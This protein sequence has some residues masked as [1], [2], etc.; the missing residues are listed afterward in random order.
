MSDPE[1]SR[2]PSHSSSSSSRKKQSQSPAGHAQERHDHSSPLA[3]N[4]RSSSSST[5]STAGR[6]LFDD[7]V[8]PP[9]TR[10][11]SPGGNANHRHNVFYS[12]AAMQSQELYSSQNPPLLPLLP[13][14]Q[15][16]QHQS[17]STE[18]FFEGVVGFEA[19]LQ[20]LKQRAEKESQRHVPQ[21]KKN[22]K[23]VTS[24]KHNTGASKKEK[25]LHEK[26]D[27]V[28]LHKRD[29]PS[30]PRKRSPS[31]CS[32]ASDR[33]LAAEPPHSPSSSW[34]WDFFA[35]P[36]TNDGEENVAEAAAQQHD[37]L[38]DKVAELDDMFERI[39][40]AVSWYRHEWARKHHHAQQLR[41]IGA[42]GTTALADDATVL[43][44]ALIAELNASSSP[45]VAPSPVS[46]LREECSMRTDGGASVLSVSTSSKRL[47]GGPLSPSM[48][49][50]ARRGL[51][52]ATDEALA[53]LH[54]RT[55]P[56]VPGCGDGGA[57]GGPSAPSAYFS[58]EL[59]HELD[60]HH[61]HHRPS[62]VQGR[63]GTDGVAQLTTLEERKAF[64]AHRR[65]R[66]AQQ[67]Q[68]GTAA[69][70]SGEGH[71][72]TTHHQLTKDR[73]LHQVERKH[74]DEAMSPSPHRAAAD[75]SVSPLSVASE[76]AV[77]SSA[78]P[79]LMMILG[80]GGGGGGASTSGAAA[81]THSVLSSFEASPL[82]PRGP[83][84]S[85]CVLPPH[86]AEATLVEL[87]RRATRAA[88]QLR[89]LSHR[90]GLLDRICMQEVHLKNLREE[91]AGL[92]AAVKEFQQQTAQSQ[93]KQGYA[94]EAELDA[95]LMAERLKHQAMIRSLQA[96]AKTWRTV[97][98]QAALLGDVD[99]K[100]VTYLQEKIKFQ[101]DHQLRGGDTVNRLTKYLNLQNRLADALQLACEQELVTARRGAKLVESRAI[102]K[103]LTHSTSP[104]P[105][106]K[107]PSRLRTSLYASVPSAGRGDDGD[108]D[109]LRQ[110]TK[111]VPLLMSAP[112]VPTT[113]TAL[114]P[115]KHHHRGKEG[116]PSSVVVGNVWG[117]MNAKMI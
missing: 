17:S 116:S 62:V 11:N 53:M 70:R 97:Q 29:H 65:Q 2:S 49:P 77:S 8:P 42:S 19:E 9:S 71:P 5:A 55:I 74:N 112:P 14:Q 13:P 102:L 90:N 87:T 94:N 21:R 117:R 85:S 4:S 43:S 40:E 105:P 38:L 81:A 114:S 1:R 27:E 79:S 30:L 23:N 99:E 113:T 18:N 64:L 24:K 34:D 20:A 56:D 58:E 60:W 10:S 73:F 89:D 48:S 46:A 69:A 75:R 12:S 32:A 66:E 28:V 31:S 109:A 35:P 68:K 104:S 25:E 67:P 92:E 72:T 57:A 61:P 15:Q 3:P 54:L 7:A 33:S 63:V 45:S 44:A 82:L 39:V 37:I 110:L 16:H 107:R 78:S 103:P 115:V 83:S 59:G 26:E 96:E 84:S 22:V 41:V 6:S 76:C 95:F 111:S 100:R 98:Q 47:Y 108:P 93:Q 91:N 106:A 88:R 36:P 50:H 52:K 101:S 86:K 51:P 80:G